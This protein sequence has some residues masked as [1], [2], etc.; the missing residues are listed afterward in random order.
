MNILQ[1]DKNYLLCGFSLISR[2]KINNFYC[3]QPLG[4]NHF[5][6]S[7]QL[8]TITIVSTLTKH[9][10]H[11]RRTQPQTGKYH[12]WRFPSGRPRLSPLLLKVA[13][14]DGEQCWMSDTSL[15]V[16]LTLSCFI[17]RQNKAVSRPVI[18]P[19]SLTMHRDREKWVLD[20]SSAFTFC[21]IQ[22]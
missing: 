4:G 20:N 14:R 5:L 10:L 15:P 1:H 17:Q 6:A 8:Y 19:L 3:S 22:P 9:P 12:R 7:L 11:P 13:E 16:C 2:G 18:V 21:H